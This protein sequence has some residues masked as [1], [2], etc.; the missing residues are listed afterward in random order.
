[1]SMQPPAR[2]TMTPAK[3]DCPHC[4]KPVGMSWWTLLPSRDNHRI[5]TCKACG[6]HFDLANASKMAGAMGGM[7]GMALGVLL[8]FGWIVRAGHGSKLFIVAG[9]IAVAACL[10][11]GS[12]GLAR[13]LLR[14]EA[15]P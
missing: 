7:L 15:R 3:D 2:A 9:V 1:M 10:C 6:R 5:L 8:P 12:M 13:V 14:L 11:L 4:G